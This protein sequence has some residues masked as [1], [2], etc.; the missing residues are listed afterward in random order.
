MTQ[1]DALLQNI[2]KILNS[3][4]WILPKGVDVFTVLEKQC[5][6]IKASFNHFQEMFVLKDLSTNNKKEQ[7]LHVVKFANKYHKLDLF[8]PLDL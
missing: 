7:H 8:D 1:S 3:K 6:S 2:C 5:S 4:S